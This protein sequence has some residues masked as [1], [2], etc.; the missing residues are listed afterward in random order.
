MTGYQQ[1]LNTAWPSS[2]D[3]FEGVPDIFEPRVHPAHRPKWQRMPHEAL[4][5]LGGVLPGVALAAMLAFVGKLLSNFIG[6]S[7]LR[8]DSDKGSPISPIML[9]ILLGLIIRNT[10]GVPVA[11]EQGLR[12]CLKA[13]LRIG[14]VLL[15]L[16]LSL[17]VLG[18]IGL[19]GIPIIAAC[20]AT[21]LIA[22]TFIN[23]ALGLP[24]RLGTLI[25]VGTS[26]CGV[27]AIVATAPVI[28]AQEDETSYAVACITIFGMIALF[29]YPFAAHWL[30]PDPQMAGL[31][32]GTAIH[33][34]S[35]VAGAGLMYKQQ[36]LTDGALKTAMA[37]KLMRNVAMAALIPLMAILYHRS[38]GGSGSTRRMRQKWHH[39]VPMFVIGFLAMACLRTIGDVGGSRPFGVLDQPSWE[40]ITH[41]ADLAA[42]WCLMLAM[43]SVGLATGLAK[44][45]NLGWKPFSVGFAAALLV[46][47]V[48]AALVKNWAPMLMRWRD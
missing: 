23:R 22:V 28:D 32:L 20:I 11:Y 27:S 38:T 35:Q 18:R 8:F 14:I 40:R 44:L 48:S 30:F 1:I 37:V 45:K 3:S 13:V 46:G 19:I 7:L 33:D 39:L 47:G 5:W 9:A 21:A 2:L 29:V 25:A 24:E 16:K 10:V 36:F 6:I 26:I 42:V 17:G 12:F 34:T 31:F 43:A 41:A 15:G 4:V